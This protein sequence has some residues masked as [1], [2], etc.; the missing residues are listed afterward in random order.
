MTSLAHYLKLKEL[1]SL[2]AFSDEYRVFIRD[3]TRMTPLQ[4]FATGERLAQK[5]DTI[6]K[7]IK[8]R[9]TATMGSYVSVWTRIVPNVLVEMVGCKRYTHDVL[10]MVDDLRDQYIDCIRDYVGI[11]RLEFS[12]RE[13]KTIKKWIERK[14]RRG[15]IGLG[16]YSFELVDLDAFSFE[17][18]KNR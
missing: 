14:Y 8:N 18:N 2:M 4:L 10:L 3:H 15:E 7:R 9:I 12:H 5:I 16:L 1:N 6:C 17:A 13:K 11:K